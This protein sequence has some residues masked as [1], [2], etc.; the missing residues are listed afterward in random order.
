MFTK[1]RLAWNKPLDLPQ[2]EE[3]PGLISIVS[4]YFRLEAR[5]ETE[6]GLFG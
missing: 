4:P 6:N 2:F 5:L 1:R 3:M